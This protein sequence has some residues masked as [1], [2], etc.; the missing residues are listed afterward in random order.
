MYLCL[1]DAT[2]PSA[3]KSIDLMS[4]RAAIDET[5]GITGKQPDLVNEAQMNAD[6]SQPLSLTSSRRQPPKVGRERN[7]TYSLTHDLV[8]QL[9]GQ[10]SMGDKISHKQSRDI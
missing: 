3:F 10:D 1:Q 4:A 9:K 7:L 2:S 8:V 5:F 6:K